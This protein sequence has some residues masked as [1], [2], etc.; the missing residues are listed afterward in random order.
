[1]KTIAIL[2]ALSFAALAQ[3]PTKGDL[4]EHEG[5]VNGRVWKNSSTETRLGYVV[6]Y[7][8][9]V[10]SGIDGFGRLTAAAQGG[11]PMDDATV[12]KIS[13]VLCP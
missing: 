4:T 1:M 9:G 10:Y 12:D 7:L 6:G 2:L 3:Q 8:N 13:T 5:F 11:A